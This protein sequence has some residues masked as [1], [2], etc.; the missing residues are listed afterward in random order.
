LNGI[1]KMFAQVPETYEVVNHVLTLGLDTIWRKRAARLAATGG[2]SRWLDVCSG[3]GEMAVYLSRLAGRG[4]T[5][6]ASD[7]CKPMLDRAREKRNAAGI[8]FALGDTRFLPF[9]DNS[10]DLVTIS[11]ATRNINVT[12]E[13]LVDCLRE[14]HR[15]LRP[16]GRFVNLET[17][18][19]RSGL[20]RALVH[21]YVRTFVAPIGAAISRSKAG[22]SYLSRTIPRFYEAEEFQ[23]IIRSSGFRRVDFKRLVFGVAAIHEAVK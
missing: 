10:F 22:Y 17:S 11:F 2:G 6:F 14:F 21:F 20:I 5:V 19:P 15:I 4:T 12:S 18:Q 16:G 7:F 8:L 1:K 13:H 9:K 23:E 3:T